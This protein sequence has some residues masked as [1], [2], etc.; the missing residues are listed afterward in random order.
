VHGGVFVVTGGGGATR[1]RG[2]AL[3]GQVIRGLHIALLLAIPRL[4]LAGAVVLEQLLLLGGVLH[5]LLLVGEVLLAV[6]MVQRWCRPLWNGLQWDVGLAALVG[7]LEV[8]GILLEPGTRLSFPFVGQLLVQQ[9]VDFVVLVRVPQLGRLVMITGGLAGV[10]LLLLLLHHPVELGI[11]VGRTHYDGL[12]LILAAPG[13]VRNGSWRL[14]AL[15]ISFPVTFSIPFPLPLPLP[16]TFP[17][18][19]PLPLPFPFPL[20]FPLAGTRLIWFGGQVPEVAI[21]R[22]LDGALPLQLPMV[23]QGDL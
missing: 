23:G 12:D 22:R 15:A 18:P 20:Q 4:I 7:V 17:V 5:E 10:L 13:F 11:V 9:P 6:M 3:E 21:L 16:L 1:W 19:L 8:I 14:G 2:H